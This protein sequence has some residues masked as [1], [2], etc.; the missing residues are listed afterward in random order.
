M[1][2]PRALSSVK[3]LTPLP[4]P[5]VRTKLA[6]AAYIQYPA[7]TISVPGRR[8]TSAVG[9]SKLSSG[10]LYI[11]KIVP[12]ETPASKLED[13]VISNRSHE[14]SRGESEDCYHQ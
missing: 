1:N 10:S 6:L 12:T 7:H 13:P 8:T 5:V 2:S 14:Q 11:P 4:F 9:L 3:P